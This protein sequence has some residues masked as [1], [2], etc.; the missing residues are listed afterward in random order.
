MSKRTI[1]NCTLIKWAINN[2]IGSPEIQ[3]DKCLGYSRE[4]DDEP[5]NKCKLCKL[6]TTYGQ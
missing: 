1:E 2:Y 6:N 3:E 4:S 5:C